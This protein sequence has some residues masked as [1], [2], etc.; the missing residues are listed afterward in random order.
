MARQVPIVA[1]L[2]IVQGAL[3][4]LAGALFL[5]AAFVV[6]P[7]LEE[8]ARQQ[9]AGLPM[10][11]ETFKQFAMAIY[12]ALGAVALVAAP[13]RIVAGIRN[14]SYRGRG[15]GLTA[16]FVGGLS[17]LTCYCAPT[18]LGLMIYGLIV[19]FNEETAWAFRLGEQGMSTEEVKKRLEE[20]RRAVRE[21]DQPDRW[22]DA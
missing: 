17:M 2:M 15:L 3:E 22:T 6:P 7:L 14:L 4:G 1:I 18:S 8:A 11:P 20:R 9:P 13:L 16:L 10:L 12:L 19:Y 21:I 5:V